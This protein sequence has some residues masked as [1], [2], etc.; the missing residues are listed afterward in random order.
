M[1]GTRQCERTLE[2]LYER[3]WD[4]N[5]QLVTQVIKSFLEHLEAIFVFKLFGSPRILIAHVEQD[6][7]I[8]KN[9]LDGR[10]YRRARSLIDK[11]RT[12]AC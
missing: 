9:A 8:Q 12:G 10:A 6:V 2:L 7:R 4:D 3:P 1:G 5:L 11:V